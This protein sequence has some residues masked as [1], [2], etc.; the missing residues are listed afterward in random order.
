M[1]KWEL[2]KAMDGLDNDTPVMVGSPANEIM[3]YSLSDI[4]DVSIYKPGKKHPKGLILI[5]IGWRW[6]SIRDDDGFMDVFLRY[7]LGTGDMSVDYYTRRLLKEDFEIK[8]TSLMAELIEY[9]DKYK[10]SKKLK[11]N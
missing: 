1:T 2:M 9:I 11:N 5:E 3:E 6:M 7:T 8:Q 4:M 10:A